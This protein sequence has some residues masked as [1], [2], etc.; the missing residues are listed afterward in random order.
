MQRS[1]RQ[2]VRPCGAR[3]IFD[4]PHGQVQRSL[5]NYER[6]AAGA[7]GQARVWLHGGEARRRLAAEQLN[8]SEA[9]PSGYTTKGTIPSLLKDSLQK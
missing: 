8:A 5:V 2:A 6:F 7:G 9:T 1:G 3:A 4:T